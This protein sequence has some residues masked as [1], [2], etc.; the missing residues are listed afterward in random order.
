MTAQLSTSRV[1]SN[2]NYST[3]LRSC[4][5]VF[6]RFSSS[7]DKFIEIGKDSGFLRIIQRNLPSPNWI[8]DSFKILQDRFRRIFPFFSFKTVDLY[9][10]GF[11]RIFQVNLLWLDLASGHLLRSCRIFFLGEWIGFDVEFG[12]LAAIGRDAW[13]LFWDFFHHCQIAV[14]GSCRIPSGF[15]EI[16]YDPA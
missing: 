15:L 2:K 9:V 4:R 7:F 5:I 16:L 6:A 14:M 10:Q 1:T 11:F 8:W 12:F 3:E 13:R